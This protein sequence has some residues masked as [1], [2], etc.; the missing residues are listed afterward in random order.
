LEV[1][2]MNTNSTTNQLKPT[3]TRMPKMRASWMLPRGDI[4]LLLLM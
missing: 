1:K 2:M 4:G 3:P